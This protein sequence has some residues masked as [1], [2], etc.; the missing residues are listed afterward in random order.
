[1]DPVSVV[2]QGVEGT[3]SAVAVFKR[4]LY[5]AS[6]HH[7]TFLPEVTPVWVALERRLAADL[8]DVE[9]SAMLLFDAARPDLAEALLTRW[10]ATEAVAALD[11]GEAIVR[12]MEARSRVLFGVR[13][14]RGWRGPEQLW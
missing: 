9:A 1:V 10:C 6:E 5:L 3:Q 11:L 2:A 13:E 8:V 4:L 14:E 7:E 12:S